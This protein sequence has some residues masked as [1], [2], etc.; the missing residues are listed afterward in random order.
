VKTNL[1]PE[2]TTVTVPGKEKRLVVTFRG[3]PAR[4]FTPDVRCEPEGH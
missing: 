2:P 3:S 1:N 4:E